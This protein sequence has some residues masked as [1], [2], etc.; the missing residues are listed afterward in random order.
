[1]G[2]LDRVHLFEAAASVP[3]APP[4]AKWPLHKT[5][6]TVVIFC[7]VAWAAIIGVAL[8]LI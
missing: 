2:Y 7:T 8:A 4:A 6:W 5:F 1:M 3:A